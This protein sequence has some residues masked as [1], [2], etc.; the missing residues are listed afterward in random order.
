LGAGPLAVGPLAGPPTPDPTGAATTSPYPA[1]EAGSTTAAAPSPSATGSKLD[2]P[3]SAGPPTPTAGWGTPIL[4]EDFSGPNLDPTRWGVYDSPDQTPPRS[5]DAIRV[6]NGELQLIGGFNPIIGKDLSGGVE[7]TLNQLYGRWEARIRVDRGAGYSG[8]VLLWPQS[9][10]WPTDGEIDIAE[11]NMGARQSA[12]T[13][14]HNGVA[15]TR[16]VT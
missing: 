9:E 11:V 16:S 12:V 3:V 6:S 15:T 10:N 5:P 2:D 13:F 7:S 8:V 14:L 1:L 4:V